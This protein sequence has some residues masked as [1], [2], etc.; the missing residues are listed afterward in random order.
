M[1]LRYRA[2]SPWKNSKQQTAI[3][4]QLSAEY[5]WLWWWVNMR[6]ALISCPSKP[7]LRKSTQNTIDSVWKLKNGS[8]SLVTEI[9]IKSF[10]ISN[11]PHSFYINKPFWSLVASE[12]PVRGVERLVLLRSCSCFHEI[13]FSPVFVILLQLLECLLVKPMPSE[14]WEQEPVYSVHQ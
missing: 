13:V 14:R 9:L 5:W 1:I 12:I 8:T 10:L 3:S 11:K 7:L 4:N 2:I 6:S